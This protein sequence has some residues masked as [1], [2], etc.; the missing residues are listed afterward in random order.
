MPML[1]FR[2]Y[3]QH[4]AALVAAALE[5]ANPYTAVKRTMHVDGRFLKIDSRSY[6]V[7]SG[8]IFI[9]AV[10]KASVPM[11]QAAVDVLD[12]QFA[13]GIAITK[14]G[15]L[16]L[17]FSPPDNVTVYSA[18]HPISDDASILATTAVSDLL[19]STTVGDLVIC[20]ISGGTSA[21]LSAPL[22]SLSEWQALNNAL[23]ASGCTI[24][25]FNTV[26]R[27]LDAVKGGGLAQWAAP[28]ACVSL[29][30]SDVVGNP[31][32]AIGSGPTVPMQESPADAG[33]I[34]ERYHVAA[35]MD[36]AVY[37]NIQAA[38]SQ[39]PQ[40]AETLDAANTHIIIGDVGQAAQSAMACAMQLGFVSQLLT[41][42]LEGEAREAGKFAAAIAKDT[43]PGRCLI[44]GGETTVTLHGDGIGGRNQEVALAAAVALAGQPNTVIASFATDGDDGPTPPGEA[45]PAAGAVVSGETVGNGRNYHLDAQ[46]F[47]DNNDSYTYFKQ[48]DQYSEQNDPPEPQTH[49][50]PGPTGTNVN[51]LIFI[52]TYAE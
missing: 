36:T 7:D 50:R 12:A 33:A 30:L 9:I 17:D 46:K 19:A 18:G 44:L 38:L 35:K 51:D 32:A 11:L 43:L 24:N 42:H 31:L 21:L 16:P 5:A 45:T 27:Q 29:I 8:R 1:Y 15:S 26:R 39:I 34:L 40:S 41:S 47:L 25:E 48:L 13:A 3:R 37:A 2:D 20:L 6:P 28:A 49:L 22:V 4:V 52:L 14:H 23:L 10:G